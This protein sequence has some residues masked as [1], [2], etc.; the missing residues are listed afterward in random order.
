MHTATMSNSGEAGPTTYATIAVLT[1]ALFA[2]V[3]YDFGWSRG[4]RD[5]ALLGAAVVALLLVA[6]LLKSKFDKRN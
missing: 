2:Y 6:D 5:F 3:A 1:A 4:F